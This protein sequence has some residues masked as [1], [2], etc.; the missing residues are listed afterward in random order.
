MNICLHLYAYIRFV[1][2][3]RCPIGDWCCFA[4][5]NIVADHQNTQLSL[6]QHLYH[7][8]QVCLAI[9]SRGCHAVAKKKKKPLDIIAIS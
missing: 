4:K 1:V 7:Y 3:S 5:G 9:L 6:L 8:N 2:F